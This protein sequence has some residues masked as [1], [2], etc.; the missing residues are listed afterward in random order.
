MLL[1][2]Q[3]LDHLAGLSALHLS[4]EEKDR[5]FPHLEHILAFVGTLQSCDVEGIAALAHPQDNVVLETRSSV[6]EFGESSKIL[7]NVHHEMRN[8]AI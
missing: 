6:E 5:L 4:K 7:Q 8:Q 3:E 1:T 2:E